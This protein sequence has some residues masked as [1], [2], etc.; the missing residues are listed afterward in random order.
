MP[1]MTIC[2]FEYGR[3]LA[4]AEY[5]SIPGGLF[6]IL[7]LALVLY[8]FA[9]HAI[10]TRRMIGNTRINEYMMLLMQHNVLYFFLYAA[11]GLLCRTLTL[12]LR[13][14]LYKALGIGM[15]LSSSVRNS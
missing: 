13:N 3:S 1:G 15:S 7:L 2:L 12:V 14:M 10:E 6:D 8:R 4:T 9:A 5:G 11:S